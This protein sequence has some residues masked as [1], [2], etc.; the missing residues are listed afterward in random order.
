MCGKKNDGQRETP[1]SDEEFDAWWPFRDDALD[2]VEREIEEDLGNLDWCP[3]PHLDD[4][5]SRARDRIRRALSRRRQ[6][7]MGSLKSSEVEPAS[8]FDASAADGES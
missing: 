7:H 3:E 2:D 5:R 6:S 8:Q 1:L 4:K